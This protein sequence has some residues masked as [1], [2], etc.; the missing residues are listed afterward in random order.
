MYQNDMTKVEKWGEIAAEGWY[1]VRIEKGEEKES[2]ETPG[3]LVW[4]WYLRC[5]EEPFV[6]KLIMDN[7][8]LQDHALANLKA[9]YEACD[10]HPDSSGH[11][12]S[13]IIGGELL[14]KVEHDIYKGEKRAK[15]AP[16]N[17]RSLKDGVPKGR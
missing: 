8:S 10:Y 15:I 11:D 16:Y 5:Q 4:W 9:Y 7:C 1:H 3:A 14:V 2:K 17:I 12:P 13:T 6:G